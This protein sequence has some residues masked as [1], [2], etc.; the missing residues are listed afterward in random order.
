MD[1]S[2]KQK[3]IRRYIE[4]ICGFQEGGWWRREGLEFE[5]SRCKLVYIEWINNKVLLCSTGSYIQ[6]SMI[7]HNG[8]KY[9]YTE[10]KVTRKNLIWK[11][12]LFFNAA[13]SGQGCLGFPG[14]S[15]VKNLPASAGDARDVG[16]VP[17]SGRSPAVEN[18]NPFQYSCLEN[19]IDRGAL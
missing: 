9:D 2:N 6:Y 15:A 16:S 5:I 4:Q 7:N 17:E 19:F 8:K 11:K 18:N 1:I 14:G 3:Q 13:Q 12:C 10:T